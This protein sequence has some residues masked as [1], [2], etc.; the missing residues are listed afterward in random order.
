MTHG[1]EVLKKESRIK[2]L[3]YLAFVFLLSSFICVVLFALTDFGF[4]MF[5]YAGNG[6]TPQKRPYLVNKIKV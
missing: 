4:L 2:N 1:M 6:K 5:F 3:K